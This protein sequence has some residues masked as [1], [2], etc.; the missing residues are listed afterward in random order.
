MCKAVVDLRITIF[1]RWVGLSNAAN[2]GELSALL[3][4][5]QTVAASV[6]GGCEVECLG[7]LS[8]NGTLLCLVCAPTS[9]VLEV[10]HGL[11]EDLPSTVGI[12]YDSRQRHNGIPP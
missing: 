4:E 5:R 10:C 1:C 12:E 2:A 9:A 7:Q 6:A 3:R 11:L 8:V